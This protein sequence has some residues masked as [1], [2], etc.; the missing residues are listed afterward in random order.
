METLFRLCGAIAAKKQSS[1]SVASAVVSDALTLKVLAKDDRKVLL[2]RAKERREQ[3]NDLIKPLSELTSSG[4]SRSARIEESARL[5]NAA[6]NL[7]SG[8]SR[9]DLGNGEPMSSGMHHHTSSAFTVHSAPDSIRSIAALYSLRSIASLLQDNPLAQGQ[10]ARETG[11]KKRCFAEGTQAMLKA[12]MEATNDGMNLNQS[13][14]RAH[15]F[16][17][18]RV[19]LEAIAQIPQHVRPGIWMQALTVAGTCRAQEANRGGSEYEMP[20]R[21]LVDPSRDL[22]SIGYAP[23]SQSLQL[24]TELS[25]A[26]PS[27]NP[28]LSWGRATS[29]ALSPLGDPTVALMVLERLLQS[30]R[31]ADAIP[32]H[33]LYTA[34]TSIISQ[35]QV[36]A[37]CSGKGQRFLLE[38]PPLRS[39]LLQL[40]LAARHPSNMLG[41]TPATIPAFVLE[42][43]REGH[44]PITTI[45]LAPLTLLCRGCCKLGARADQVSS[46]PRTPKN[47]TPQLQL[48]LRAAIAALLSVPDNALLPFHLNGDGGSGGH[49]PIQWKPE[50]KTA[51]AVTL[52][53]EFHSSGIQALEEECELFV[54]V[55]A[56]LNSTSSSYQ[57]TGSGRECRRILLE[58]W[59]SWLSSNHDQLL[60]IQLSSG[61]LGDGFVRLLEAGLMFAVQ[62][63]AA[64]TSLDCHDSSVL[65]F[66]AAIKMLKKVSAPPVVNGIVQGL[67]SEC[68]NV[69]SEVQLVG[70]PESTRNLIRVFTIELLSALKDCAQTQAE[71]KLALPPTSLH[72]LGSLVLVPVSS[73]EAQLLWIQ[74]AGSPDATRLVLNT[75]SKDEHI[76]LELHGILRHLAFGAPAQKPMSQ[77][78]PA[79]AS[80]PLGLEEKQYVSLAAA[81]AA[82][83]TKQWDV[84]LSTWSSVSADLK[85]SVASRV[86]AFCE[87]K[88]VHPPWNSLETLLR[89]LP[90]RET[91]ESLLHGLLE[92]AS[93]D[94]R[95]TLGL[96]LHAIAVDKCPALAQRKSIRRELESLVA[97]MLHRT[98]LAERLGRI[99]HKAA[100]RQWSAAFELIVKSD[101]AWDVDPSRGKSNVPF[102]KDPIYSIDPVG[103]ESVPLAPAASETTSAATSKPF[104]GGLGK[105][106][107]KHRSNIAVPPLPADTEGLIEEHQT[108]QRRNMELLMQ[109]PSVVHTLTYCYLAAKNWCAALQVYQRRGMSIDSVPRTH[110]RLIVDLVRPRPAQQQTMQQATA[111]AQPAAKNPSA[112]ESSAFPFQNQKPF[113]SFVD[114][115]SS[116]DSQYSIDA[117]ALDLFRPEQLANDIISIHQNQTAQGSATEGGMLVG[118]TVGTKIQ[119]SLGSIT[120]QQAI[121]RVFAEYRAQTLWIEAIEFYQRLKESKT[122]VDPSTAMSLVTIC[123]GGGQWKLSIQYFSRLSERHRPTA[124]AYISVL[125]ACRDGGSW[126]SA[127]SIVNQA[128][129]FLPA[130]PSR[131]NPDELFSQEHAVSLAVQAA[132][133]AGNWDAALRVAK[134]CEAPSLPKLCENTLTAL[135]EKQLWMETVE[136]FCSMVERGVRPRSTAVTTA[137]KA[138][139]FVKHECQ[140]MV[141]AVFSFSSGLEDTIVILGDKLVQ[142]VLWVQRKNG[143]VLKALFSTEGV[144]PSGSDAV[145]KRPREP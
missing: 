116:L 89:Y 52:L 108:R 123:Q 93:R 103:A 118:R 72:A 129:H 92:Q 37:T 121:R 20:D 131:Q 87:T 49:E 71:R 6:A 14:N 55:W 130:H 42:L 133:K 47:A 40:F 68:A 64:V 13:G 30:V 113:P 127:I 120:P 66:S 94:G 65:G 122:P 79:P 3:L 10:V 48:Q 135:T 51:L 138:C 53:R 134:L 63:S 105:A 126:Q 31:M 139:E 142:H 119:P 58:K 137:L 96:R 69:A 81:C 132:L 21:E 115:S 32:D 11:T 43:A 74:Y 67:L 5:L 136:Y 38:D 18:S 114:Y 15:S 91:K 109:I 27:L 57:S 110:R 29:R 22:L 62:A 78:S 75:F 98:S 19:A 99:G 16:N 125:S 33:V 117:V 41:V 128:R 88:H 100:A 35:L 86:L 26:S 80:R 17:R 141:Q 44:I 124:A 140:L 36:T 9:S 2:S 23:W 90:A 28:S 54:R 12:A 76:M 83:S 70:L 112:A 144:D 102:S 111:N 97:N 46:A 24:V 8:G 101:S 107:Q 34:G 25:M 4:T 84:A 106:L 104:S 56:T 39:G 143:N 85:P 61:G 59:S 73:P 7:C 95:W 50:S 1:S 45:P 82:F 77:G 60:A 145:S